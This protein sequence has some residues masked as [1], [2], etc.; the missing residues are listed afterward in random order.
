MKKSKI[1]I[2]LPAY[3]SKELLQKVFYPSFYRNCTE[4]VELVVYDN[5]ND[6]PQHISAS[7]HPINNCFDSSGRKIKFKLI[8]EGVNIGLNAALN[9]C[10]KV[11]TGEYFYLPHTDMYLMPGWDMASLQ[12][13]NFFALAAS[14]QQR[15]IQITTSSKTTAKSGASLMKRLFWKILKIITIPTLF[16]LPGCPSFFIES[17]GMPWAVLIQI[18]SLIA[19]TM[20]W[21]KQPMIKKSENSI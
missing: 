10:A 21:C 18:I 8:G 13:L 2:L 4:D 12:E 15:D 9:E 6:F 11:A 19:L 17:S 16:E 3:K 5:G 20:I 7:I 14:S 1:S